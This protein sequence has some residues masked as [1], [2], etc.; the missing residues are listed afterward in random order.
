MIREFDPGDAPTAAA[1]VPEF[2]VVTPQS[3]RHALA[4]FPPRYKY[5]AYDVAAFGAR[6]ERRGSPGHCQLIE[7]IC[8]GSAM[9]FRVT[10]RG[11]EIDG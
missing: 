7:T 10:V 5:A 11:S 3:L 2:R 4:T 9:P 6:G 8:I 1:F